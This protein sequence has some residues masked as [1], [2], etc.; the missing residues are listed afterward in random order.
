MIIGL[1]GLIGSGKDTA[2]NILVNNHGFTKTSF[3]AILKDITAKIFSWDREA[4]EGATD[5]SR[6]WRE[7]KD[8]WWSKKFG[9]DVT[10]R[11]ILQKI[12]T[13]A[14]RNHIHDSIW[15]SALEKSLLTRYKTEDIVVSDVRFPNEITMI[16]KMDGRVWEISRGVFP[17]WYYDAAACNKGQINI[18]ETAQ[19]I[20]AFPHPSEWKWIGNP[21]IGAMVSNTGTIQDLETTLSWLLPKKT[22]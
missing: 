16:L 7:T 8:E 11:L 1:C 5:E 2:A 10:P 13:E 22:D 3:A 17:E 21:G 18:D 9:F 4:L 19:K 15:V 6:K 14:M 12:G 20:L